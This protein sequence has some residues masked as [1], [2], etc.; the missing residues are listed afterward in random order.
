MDVII[1]G[2]QSNMQGCTEG[3]PIDNEVVNGACEYLYKTN[4][5]KPLNHPVGEN[6]GGMDGS[7]YLMQSTNGGGSLVPYFCRAYINETGREVFAIH[8]ARG[9]TTIGQWLYGTQRYHYSVKKIKAG[10]Q[11]ASELGKIDHIYYVWLQGESDAVIGTT[12]EEYF[13]R[14]VQYKNSL[15]KDVGIEKF[16][17]IRV[18]YFCEF[19]AWYT[20]SVASAE[21]GK[22]C[23]ET[24]M[25]SQEKAVKEDSDFVMLTRVCSEI[26]RQKEYIN[27]K[28]TAHYNNK[29][30][31]IIGIEAGKG[32]AKICK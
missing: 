20:S 15:K 17:I 14:L 26:S 28:V 31:E 23:D 29:G 5:V 22:K 32:L 21:V 11:K 27:P 6:Y 18:G 4:S 1:F 9:N 13:D 2:G 7:E 10:L 16:C 3:C 19:S 8:T 24:I 25:S 12:L 30:M